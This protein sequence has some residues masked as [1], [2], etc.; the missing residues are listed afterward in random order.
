VPIGLRLLDPDGEARLMGDS[1]RPGPQ[2]NAAGKLLVVLP[3]SVLTG[4]STPLTIGVYRDSV[5]VHTV[6]T[7]FLGPGGVR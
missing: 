7:S 3:R 2:E 1:L 5:L 6:T 4:I